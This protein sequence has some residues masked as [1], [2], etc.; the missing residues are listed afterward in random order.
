[1]YRHMGAGNSLGQPG[2]KAPLSVA[3]SL[4]EAIREV[5][6]RSPSLDP[7]LWAPFTVYVADD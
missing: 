4:A 2:Q 5:L 3:A 6:R 7:A 1:M